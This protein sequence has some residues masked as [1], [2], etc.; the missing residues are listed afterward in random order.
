MSLC[1]SD[2]LKQSSARHDHLCPRQVLG[3]RIGLAGLAILE[4]DPPVNKGTALIIIESDGCFADGIEVATGATIGHRTLHVNDFGK[5]AATFADVKTG[6]AIRISPALDVRERAPLYAPDEPRHYFA[7]LQGYQVMPD[8]ELLRIQEV[9]LN[10]T[11][12]ELISKPL[13]RVHCDYCG[14]DIINEREVIVNGAVVCRTCA[15]DGYYLIKT[16]PTET[17]AI[18]PHASK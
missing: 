2:L 17:Y 15:N 12:E 11:L 10:P 5:M 4:L 6:R 18:M 16:A 9:A 1:I 3:V 7:Q 14:E 8:A 13:V